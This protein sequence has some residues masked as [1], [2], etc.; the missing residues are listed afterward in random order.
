MAW[1]EL[2]SGAQHA[3]RQRQRGADDQPAPASS[4]WPRLRFEPRR[5]RTPDLR[6]DL[7]GLPRR[8][9]PGHAATHAGPRR[10]ETHPAGDRDDHRG[11]PQRHAG[12]PSVPPQ[13]AQCAGGVPEDTAGRSGTER[14]R[15]EASGPLH[16]R[17]LPAVPRSARRA[18][19]RAAVGDTE[20]DRSRQG[21]H[22]L[23]GPARRIPGSG[24]EGHP[25]HRH[26]QLRRCGRHGRWR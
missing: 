14:S 23:E 18:G 17:R 20:R 22:R 2:R 12:I 7:R 26:A 10:P 8:V 21:R 19:N 25:Q 6:P 15:G 13:R 4:R 9:A 5:P 11:R 24:Q 1:S 3:L 16:D